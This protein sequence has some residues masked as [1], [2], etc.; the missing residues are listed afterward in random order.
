MI[1]LV[2]NNKFKQE[3]SLTSLWRSIKT[4][5]I[6]WSIKVKQITKLC[7]NTTKFMSLTVS[8]KCSI[9]IAPIVIR[10]NWIS[11]DPASVWRSCF[12][13]A[14][15]V[16]RRRVT[17]QLAC[18][19]AHCNVKV[20]IVVR[21]IFKDSGPKAQI[22][23]RVV[24]VPNES[25]PVQ[26]CLRQGAGT[27]HTLICINGSIIPGSNGHVLLERNP[28]KALFSFILL[29]SIFYSPKISSKQIRV[30]SFLVE[31]VHSKHST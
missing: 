2:L 28:T 17:T 24:P 27:R 14:K 19:K 4:A 7:V 10:I 5:V 9:V 16:L 25:S 22:R 20:A 11:H 1:L 12:K 29:F 6:S 15:V 21:K 26:K 31:V 13:R 3:Q 30:S 18:P 8:I 23:P